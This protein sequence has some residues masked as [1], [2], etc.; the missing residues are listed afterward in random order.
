[1]KEINNGKRKERRDCERM[2]EDGELT[3]KLKLQFELMPLKT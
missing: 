2:T 3:I 1:M